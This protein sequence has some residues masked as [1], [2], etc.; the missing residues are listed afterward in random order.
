M[1]LCDF[2][3][4]KKIFFLK[5]FQNYYYFFSLVVNKCKR[6]NGKKLEGKK[7]F[8]FYAFCAD[9]NQNAKTLIIIIFFVVYEG[10]LEQKKNVE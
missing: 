10:K 4:K 1:K 6:R 3:R 9:T 7:K 2:S 8:S 5:Q